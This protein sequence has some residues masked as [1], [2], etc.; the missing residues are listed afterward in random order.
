M[1][2]KQR[3]NDSVRSWHCKISRVYDDYST[4]DVQ[5]YMLESSVE[6]I[7]LEMLPRREGATISMYL[8]VPYNDKYKVMQP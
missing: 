3:A 1:A 8:V 6:P 2:N 4:N 5:Q 7:K